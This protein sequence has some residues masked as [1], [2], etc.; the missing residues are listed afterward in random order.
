MNAELWI[1]FY[2]WVGGML[3]TML[4]CYII[5]VM[6]ISSRV[7]DKLILTPEE[8]RALFK[9]LLKRKIDSD[10]HRIIVITIAWP[11]FVLLV[12]CYIVLS[13][14][15]RIFDKVIDITSKAMH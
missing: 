9:Y 14:T 10:W 4:V 7:K 1:L 5:A 8:K 6:T 15:T 2:C 3:P 12:S 11:M 13:T